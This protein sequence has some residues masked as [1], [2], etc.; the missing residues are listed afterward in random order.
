MGLGSRLWYDVLLDKPAEYPGDRRAVA[1]A[2]SRDGIHFRKP[3]LGLVA[4]DGST[5][6]N[7]VMPT[8]LERLALAGGSVM[9]DENPK[10]PPGERYKS[11]AKLYAKR[12]QGPPTQGG[13]G[14][15]VEE[16]GGNRMWYSPDGLRWT[17]YPPPPGCAARTPSP[18]GS[19][20]SGSDATS[21]KPR[22]GGADSRE[23]SA[24]GGLQRVG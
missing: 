14:F 23:D 9:R 10:C 20:T 17:L 2:E 7:L 21:G 18:H 16:K 4:K 19:G 24:H 22:V 3:I 13:G 11:W 8:D 15:P 12:R 1:Y 5:Q 6:N